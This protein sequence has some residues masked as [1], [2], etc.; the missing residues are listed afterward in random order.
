MVIKRMLRSYQ[1]KAS[2]YQDTLQ[3]PWCDL[4]SFITC[5]LELNECHGNI[6]S[7]YF[8]IML[9]TLWESE[10]VLMLALKIQDIRES[11]T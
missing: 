11:R 4:G 2:L 8:G 6:M 9:I 5:E 7:V 10:P 3:G 1:H